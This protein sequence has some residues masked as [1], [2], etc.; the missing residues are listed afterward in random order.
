MPVTIGTYRWLHGGI[1]TRNY[2][3]DVY[4]GMWLLGTNTKILENN[5]ILYVYNIPH[6]AKVTEKLRAQGMKSVVPG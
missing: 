1:K 3:D 4:Y 2:F 5:N 6:Y